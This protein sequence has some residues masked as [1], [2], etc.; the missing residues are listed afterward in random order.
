MV[1]C[2]G[3]VIFVF[4]V[5]VSGGQLGLHCIC[6]AISMADWADKVLRFVSLAVHDEKG[7]DSAK[8]V[9]QMRQHGC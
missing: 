6:K 9:K 1:L 5:R 2:F 3:E 8:S 4:D 7:Q